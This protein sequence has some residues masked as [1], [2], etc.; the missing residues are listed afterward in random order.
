M[1]RDTIASEVTRL[2]PPEAA[3]AAG[4]LVGSVRGRTLFEEQ[5]LEISAQPG[6]MVGVE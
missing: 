2:A 3:D 1:D 6:A 4:R 5:A